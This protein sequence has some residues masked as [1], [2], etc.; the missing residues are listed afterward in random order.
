MTPYLGWLR[1]F[2][3]VSVPSQE[4]TASQCCSSE[5]FAGGRR[6]GYSGGVNSSRGPQKHWDLG[7]LRVQVGAVSPTASAP[8]SQVSGHVTIPWFFTG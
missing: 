4:Q 5:D 7:G 8:D 3:V 2:I 1:A 6:A